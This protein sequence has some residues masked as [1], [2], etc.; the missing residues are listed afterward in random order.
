MFLGL[1]SID[2][3]DVGFDWTEW[4]APSCF[5]GGVI[6]GGR[7]NSIFVRVRTVG[8]LVGNDTSRSNRSRA[9]R[10]DSR[11]PYPFSISAYIWRG[12]ERPT[13]WPNV[14]FKFHS[15][16]VV[17]A[18]HQASLSATDR[19]YVFNNADYFACLQAEDAEQAGD[20]R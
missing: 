10:K 18:A 12:L 9:H 5:G 20:R 1:H 13:A 3:N 6:I 16:L 2:V 15:V 19:D 14:G 17:H 11:T 7:S 4:M 8:S